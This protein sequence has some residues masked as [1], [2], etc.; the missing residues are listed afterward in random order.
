MPV[1][2]EPGHED[3][4]V[5]AH[6]P[7]FGKHAFCFIPEGAG[8][9]VLVAILLGFEELLAFWEADSDEADRDGDPGRGPEDCLL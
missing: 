1:E 9:D 8:R 2:I 6:L 4:A 7:L 5:D 3:H